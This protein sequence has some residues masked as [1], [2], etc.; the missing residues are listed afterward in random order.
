M[1]K[2]VLDEV[3]NSNNISKINENFTKLET[4]LN[5]QI[6]YRDNPL[7]EP[8]TLNTD[9]DVNGKAVYNLP[10]PTLDSQAA[11]LKDVQNAISGDTQ[12]N[13]IG[14]TPAGNISATNVQE[15]IN[16]LD[17]EKVSLV[18]LATSTGSSLVGYGPL[19]LD[20]ILKNSVG[21]IVTSITALRAIDKT[22]YTEAYVTGY[23]IQGDGGGGA[24]W[25]D[26]SDTSSTDNGGTIIVAS[27]GGRW[28][29][30]G[31]KSLSVFQFGAKG[32]KVTDDTVAIQN[33]YN[34][35]PLGG[36]M[37]IPTAP[38]NAYIVSK[39]G[40]N[41]YVLNFSRFVNIKADGFFSSLQPITGTTVNTVVLTP[42]PATVYYGMEWDGLCLGDPYT[43]LRNGNNG[44][45]ID[46]Q[47]V[48]SQLPKPIFRRLSI[49]TGSIAGGV[50]IVHVNNATNN[51]NGGMYGAS[52]ENCSQLKGGISLQA[53]GDSNTIYK[54]IIS[55]PNVGVYASLVIGASLL[56]IRDNNITSTG[57]AIKIDAGSRTKITGNNMEQTV[58][59]TGGGQYMVDFVGAN[60]TMS[61]PEIT[62]NHFGAF[63]GAGT[64]ANIRLANCLN[65]LVENNTL[66][67][68]TASSTATIIDA[69]CN[70]TRIGMN[71]YGVNITTQVNN[72]GAASIG[73]NRPLTLQNS[74]VA[75]TG[76][77]APFAIKDANGVVRIQAVIASGTAT[78]G[79]VILT[80]P[81]DLRPTTSINL[82]VETSN[83]GTPTPGYISIN[84]ATGNLTIQGGANGQMDLVIG[85][86]GINARSFIS[87]L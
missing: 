57:G 27:D 46:T 56:T 50:A 68:G 11:R 83:A 52:I 8:N 7:G 17:S 29:L 4:A 28:K 21:K 58:A 87:D 65:A 34:A 78:P 37:I 19:L 73:V 10:A 39:Q 61:L 20:S 49:G 85:F 26:V 86:I 32:D 72:S 9:V 25:Y 54:N 66:L 35:V 24:Y 62:G 55:G 30:A 51:I 1:A 64:L 2:I 70:S 43:G 36:T 44:I 33:C 63:T 48:G 47:V 59:I 79:T 60:G 12:A 40:A 81:V 22:K 53:S 23:Y 15:A 67:S 13:L 41:G 14:N 42:D 75:Q 38:G 16:E 31:T 6:Y 18:Q 5:T 71:T 45:F 69:N 76:F 3:T 77:P 74:W 84:A 80:L 82:Q